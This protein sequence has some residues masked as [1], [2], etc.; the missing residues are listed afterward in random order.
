MPN[1]EVFDGVAAIVH[2]DTIVVLWK[3]A[4]RVPRSRWFFDLAHGLVASRPAG[5]LCLQIIL[6]SASPPDGPTRALNAKEIRRLE[7]SLRRVVTVPVGGGLWASLIRTIMRSMFVVTGKG[8]LQI[9][10]STEAEGLDRLLEMA[11]P[12]T[13]S[14]AE[15]LAHVKALYAA[16]DVR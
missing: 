2:G 1:V 8:G 15:L 14:R 7:P 5:V 6:E 12:E 4:A 11:G 13:P 9:V 3:A 16:L 10:T